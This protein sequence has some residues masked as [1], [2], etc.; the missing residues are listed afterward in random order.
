VH[1]PAGAH[2]SSCAPAYGWDLPHL[3]AY[4]A[5]AEDPQQTA[6]YLRDVVGVDEAAYLQRAGGPSRI[7]ALPL[8]IL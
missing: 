1:A 8:P 4:C 2:P 3:K 7:A 5:S 6:A